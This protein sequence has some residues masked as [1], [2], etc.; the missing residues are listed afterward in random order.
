M[1][2][3]RKR[4]LEMLSDG[5]VSVDEAERLL[6]LVDDEPE[7]VRPVQQ[8][9]PTRN[10]PAKYL[11]VTVDSD[12]EHVNVRVPLALIK[13][14]VKLHALVP[15]QAVEGINEALKRNGLNIDLHKLRADS[16]EELV[17]ALSDIEIDVQD[18][19]ERVRVYCE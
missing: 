12:D 7:S 1:T 16:L 5:R 4:V 18:E 2:E 10:G 11:R 19:D 14:G 9:V 3:N 17:D 15:T 13:A 8:L 6:S